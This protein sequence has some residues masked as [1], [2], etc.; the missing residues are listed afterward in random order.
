MLPRLFTPPVFAGFT[1]VVMLLLAVGEPMMLL[2]WLGAGMV[3]LAVGA[4]RDATMMMR[5]DQV[6]SKLRMPNGRHIFWIAI[7]LVLAAVDE[8]TLVIWGTGVVPHSA[9]PP[10]L[11]ALC[12]G[13]LSGRA[14]AVAI[15]IPYAPN[16]EP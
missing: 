3:G 6:R 14:I 4:I 9:F 8:V 2:I 15:R 11:A 1:A 12:A 10:G 5:V 13:L 16:D 7:V